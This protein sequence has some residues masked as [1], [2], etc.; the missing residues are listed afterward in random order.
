MA[1]KTNELIL[2]HANL[3][4][5][6][7]DALPELYDFKNFMFVIWMHL[8]LPAPTPL[9]YDIADYLQYGPRRKMVQAFRG[10]AK[11]YITAAYVL[12]RLYLDPQTIIMVV[13]AN[14]ERAIQ[15][16]VFVRQL[17]REVEL[18]KF[19]KPVGS[20]RDSSEGFVVGPAFASQSPSVRAVGIGGQM[21]GGR[22]DDVIFDDVEVPSN[23]ESHLMRARLAE[24]VKEA[25]AV[26]KPNGRVTYLGTPQSEMSVYNLLPDRGYEIK[27]WPAR[28]PANVDKYSGRLSDFILK[29]IANG[30]KVGDSV[31]PTRFSN[32]D[33]L[34]REASYGRSGFTLQFML[35]TTLSDMDKHPL[36]LQDLIVVGLDPSMAPVKLSWTCDPEK[37]LQHLQSLG[38]GSDRY[39]RPMFISPESAEYTG[40]VMAIDP[41]GKGKDMTAYA[42]IKILHGRLF[43]VDVGN[44]ASGYD[45]DALQTLSI[46]AKI[47]KVNTV[48]VESN[49][50]GGMFTSLLKP[51]LHK[52]HKCEVVE[53]RHST[54]KEKRIIDTLE[55][56]LNQHRL[57]VDEAVI[58][59]DFASAVDPKYKLFYQLA[60]ITKDRGSLAH[61]DALDALAMA[62]AYWVEQMAR[63][64]DKAAAEH[65]Q[66]ELDK[67][68]EDFMRHAIGYDNYEEKTW[69]D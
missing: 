40:S 67:K 29:L 63:D 27:V 35:D 17:I 44:I 32:E 38:L 41:A 2:A 60:R 49:F 3:I 48:L 64:T 6:N 25:D 26:L 7:P 37:C 55:P 20:Q 52:I 65:Y 46:A 12:W 42:I 19:L 1:D 23:S 47:H 57:V 15:F 4:V 18:L 9:Q 10:A 58:K 8:N 43:L 50:G 45:N 62:V 36:K 61:D 53:V 11:S 33:L 69:F 14:E 22:A 16:T 59:K 51:V 31:E 13:S 66:E 24:K 5:T 30:A 68:L 54:Q 28:I 34:E 21:T 56:I 39:Y